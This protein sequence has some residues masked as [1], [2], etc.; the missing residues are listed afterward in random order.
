[1]F[2]A[3]AG[4]LPVSSIKGAVGHMI[5]AAGAVEAAVTALSVQQGV[6]PP[7]LFHE[8]G[9]PDCDLDYVPNQARRVPELSV[10][11]SNSFG[12]GGNNS[13]LAFRKIA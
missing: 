13:V 1:V 4:S 6:I 12:M 10:A 8:A 3:H 11:I 9:D 7:T 5:G 2:G